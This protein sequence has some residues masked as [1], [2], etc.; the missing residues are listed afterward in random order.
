MRR[1]AI[2]LAAGMTIWVGSAL[3]AEAQTIQ[4]QPVGPTAAA[5]FTPVTTYAFCTNYITPGSTN[6]YYARIEVFVDGESKMFVPACYPWD[7]YSTLGTKTYRKAINLTSLNLQPGQTLKFRC[8][9]SWTGT[10]NFP[11]YADSP[12]FTVQIQS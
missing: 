6:Q 1:I 12:T 3:A 4:I 5:I 8:E 9:C 2:G 10:D 11:Y 7:V